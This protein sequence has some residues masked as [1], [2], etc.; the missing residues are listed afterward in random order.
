VLAGTY[1]AF[2]FSG[3]ASPVVG[4]AST[5]TLTAD[6]MG[7]ASR[8][9]VANSLGTVSG[10]TSQ[11]YTYVVE[12]N[13]SLALDAGLLVTLRGGV[14]ADGECA[15]L[16]AAANGLNPTVVPLFRRSGALSAASLSGAYH[17]AIFTAVPSTGDS[18]TFAG[19]VTFDGVGGA[20]FSSIHHNLM[21]LL[22]TSTGS[23]AYTVA[24][25][26]T[27]VAT[28][29]A[30]QYTG[31]VV[32]GGALGIWGGSVSSGQRPALIAVVRAGASATLATFQGDYWWLNLRRRP[33]SSEIYS[34]IA[35]TLTADGAGGLTAMGLGNLEGSIVSTPLLTESYTVE[36]GGKLTLTL[37]GLTVG[38]ITDDGRFA[39]SS[40]GIDPVDAEPMINFFVRK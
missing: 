20:S 10:P 31:G 14:T 26:G 1:F 38:G 12:P 19:P 29:G 7:N 21:G 30:G 24:G 39:I 28:F 40:G 2:Q 36:A 6:G 25:D 17:I 15:L 33:D 5:G 18:E 37:G 8:T 35:G 22:S 11:S 16:G 23:F 4:F 34:S 9:Y 32:S 13:G 3:A 27:S